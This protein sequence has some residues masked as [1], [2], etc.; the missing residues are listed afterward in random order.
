MSGIASGG[1]ARQISSFGGGSGGFD[2]MRIQ[3][4]GMSRS[5]AISGNADDAIRGT[6]DD[7]TIS[8]W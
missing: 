1:P 7:A 5:V 3:G 8:R 2:M 4:E 6:N